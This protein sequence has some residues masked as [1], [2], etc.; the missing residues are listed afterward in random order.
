MGEWSEYFEDFPE[1]N[2]ANYINGRFDPIAAK[3]LHQR[4]S[5]IA[6]DTERAR[7]EISQLLRK[8]WEA[9]K[10]QSMIGVENCPQCG[11][12]EL[13][14]YKIKDDYYLCECQECDIFGKGHT[15]D[16]AFAATEAALGEDLNWR[17]E[18]TPWER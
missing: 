2:P 7:A 6:Q 1:E 12:N 13:N 9:E 8:A 10:R 4:Q 18:A 5:A 16:D 15:R 14:V 11:L 17:D 3:Q